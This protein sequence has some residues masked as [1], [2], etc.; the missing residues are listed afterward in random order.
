MEA[1]DHV[2]A[3]KSL[4]VAAAELSVERVGEL[5]ELAWALLERDEAPAEQSVAA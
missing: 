5:A 3:L 1:E 4:L 2:Q